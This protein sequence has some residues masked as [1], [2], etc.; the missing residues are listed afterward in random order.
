V[1]S[2]SCARKRCPGRQ[3][4]PRNFLRE[5]LRRGF[6]S[7]RCQTRGAM[8][9]APAPV[10]APFLHHFLHLPETQPLPI[11]DLRSG[12]A[13]SN[14]D[15]QTSSS[16]DLRLPE[17]T[18]SGKEGTQKAASSPRP[19]PRNEE[20]QSEPHESEIGGLCRKL[21]RKLYRKWPEIDKVYEL[22]LRP[23]WPKMHCWDRL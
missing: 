19:S 21:N 1:E 23:S 9:R 11:N 3:D 7:S 13:P 14:P 8:L 16:A 6:G 18:K 22:S 12:I 5:P 20:R 10:F 17:N 4:L 2:G 15:V